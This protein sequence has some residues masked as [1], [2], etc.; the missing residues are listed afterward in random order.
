VEANRLVEARPLGLVL[1]GGAIGT[2]GREGLHLLLPA[3]GG[4]PWSVFLV[5]IVGA[6]LLGALLA[7]LAA[8]EP[9]TPRRREVRL[10]VGTGILGGFT[11]YSALA[12]DTVLLAGSRP[13]S[14][15]D[16][17]RGER[18]PRRPRRGDRLSCRAAEC[19][20]AC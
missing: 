10:F 8:V 9:E 14:G 7:H 3:E 5:N 19:R 11:T 16:V 12:T 18:R 1:L 2:A 4:I 13:G 17:C 15:D 6:A 20:P